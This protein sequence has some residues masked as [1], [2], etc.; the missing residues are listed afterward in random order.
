[1][2]IKRDFSLVTISILKTKSLRHQHRIKSVLKKMAFKRSEYGTLWKVKEDE[3]MKVKAYITKLTNA[4]NKA[5]E[6]AKS[7]NDIVWGK[8]VKD[9]LSQP[10]SYG[11]VEEAL[12]FGRVSELIKYQPINI[13][14]I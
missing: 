14:G 1:M 13:V 7:D 3:D 5:M 10:T 12:I 2:F 9:N 4:S 6:K 8:Y 11:T